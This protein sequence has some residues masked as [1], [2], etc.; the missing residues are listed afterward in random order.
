MFNR[1]IRT[2]SGESVTMAEYFKEIH[3]ELNMKAKEKL[4]HVEEKCEN[5]GVNT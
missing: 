2:P 4:A 3:D 1:S 5:D